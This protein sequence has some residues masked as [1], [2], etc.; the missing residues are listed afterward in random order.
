MKPIEKTSARDQVI[1]SLRKAIFNGDFKDGEEITQEEIAKILNVSR[2]PVR[3][4]FYALEREGLLLTQQ[5][6]RVIVKGV[7]AEDIQDH[8]DIRAMLEG[9]AAAKAASLAADLKDLEEINLEIEKAVRA[10]RT[11]EYIVANEHFHRTIWKLSNSERLQSFLDQLWNGLPPHLAEMVSEQ[12]EKAHS[13]HQ[14]ILEAL[15]NRDEDA[16]RE[17]MIQHIKRSKVDFLKV[18]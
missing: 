12:M 14:A 7:T 2:M 1:I 5:N 10:Q 6:R 3:E 4:A 9:E 13:E 11:D 17:L 16:A 15:H 8:Y 18:F